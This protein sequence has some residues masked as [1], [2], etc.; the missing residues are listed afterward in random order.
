MKFQVGDWIQYISPRFDEAE[1][2]TLRQII[3]IEYNTLTITPGIFGE[4]G[5][6][7]PEAVK[8]AGISLNQRDIKEALKVDNGN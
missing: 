6:M 4:T 3:K 8:L 7:R 5:E 2:A 1:R